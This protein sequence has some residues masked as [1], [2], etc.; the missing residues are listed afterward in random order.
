MILG[1]VSVLCDE[2]C[3]FLHN[4]KNL[5]NFSIYVELLLSL[6]YQRKGVM[7]GTSHLGNVKPNF[8]QLKTCTFK[9][10]PMKNYDGD[11]I[12]LNL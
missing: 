8:Q 5:F 6:I 9:S 11:V 12:F 1:S 2:D 7:E 10:Y 3:A 4:S